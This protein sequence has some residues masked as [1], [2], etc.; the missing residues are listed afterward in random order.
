MKQVRRAGNQPNASRSCG[1]GWRRGRENRRLLNSLGVLYA[2]Y[3][4]LDKAEF[5]SLTALKRGGVCACAAE[6]REPA[7]AEGQSR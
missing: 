3:G 5:S 2:R 4:I 1:A 6:S 7:L